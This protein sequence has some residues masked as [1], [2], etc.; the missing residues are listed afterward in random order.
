M[1]E[2][3]EALHTILYADDDSDDLMFLQDA[4]SRYSQDIKMVT[5]ADGS[6]AVNYLKRLPEEVPAPCLIILDMNM[7]RMDGR[8]ACHAIRSMERFKETPIVFFTTSS[9]H[10]D[11]TFAV[12]A[13]VGFFTK[14]VKVE[15][16]AN[17]ADKFVAHCKDDVK[18]GL[19]RKI[20]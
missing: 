19:R 4:M 17:I 14:P 8:E 9:M 11:K 15:E 16:L 5:V 10:Q 3:I 6:L 18:Q 2:N 1:Q 13:G 20:A 7:P 12:Q